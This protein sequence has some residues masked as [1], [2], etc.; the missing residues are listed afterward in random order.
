MDRALRSPRTPAREETVINKA[1][2]VGTQHVSGHV[3]DESIA[4][5]VGRSVRVSVG[6]TTSS[7]S[8]RQRVQERTCAC[9]QAAA[10]HLCS[11]TLEEQHRR[12]VS[13]ALRRRRAARQELRHRQ[14]AKEEREREAAV[15]GTLLIA[16]ERPSSRCVVLRLGSNAIL[17]SLPKPTLPRQD[18]RRARRMA[19]RE[20]RQSDAALHRSYCF[21]WASKSPP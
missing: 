15:V 3:D 6:R 14:L 7:A 19:A 16:Q 21:S 10:A 1:D 17:I 20:Q 2:V 9:D 12:V 5:V 11:V 18:R 4:L 8:A 13:N